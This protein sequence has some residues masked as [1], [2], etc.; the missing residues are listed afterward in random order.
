MHKRCGFAH[1]LVLFWRLAETPLFACLNVLA[2]WALRLESKYAIQHIAGDPE[3]H[4]LVTS[5]LSGHYLRDWSEYLN[6]I[7]AI[8]NHV[9]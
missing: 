5:E 4:V 3:S 9:L 7:A 8:V 6:T 2:V 1:S